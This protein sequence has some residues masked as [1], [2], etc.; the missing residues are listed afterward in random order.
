[1]VLHTKSF[2]LQIL[3]LSPT[4]QIENS[5]NGQIYLSKQ[6]LEAN[7]EVV[8]CKSESLNVLVPEDMEAEN[9]DFKE[10]PVPEQLKSTYK[11][12]KL[13]TVALSH[14]G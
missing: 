13:V 7:T 2:G 4:I 11:D 1:M 8:T 3:N 9:P 5:Y 12:G 10:L 14:V 6:C